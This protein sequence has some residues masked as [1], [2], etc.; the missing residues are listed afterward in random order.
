MNDSSSH[1]ND[2]CSLKERDGNV[3]VNVLH[4]TADPDIPVC[5]PRNIADLIKPH[6]I[7]ANILLH[8]NHFYFEIFNES[9]EYMKEG[10]FL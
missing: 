9:L 8:Q 2:K 5:L 6:Q 4:P 7:C 1:I 3:L 10:F